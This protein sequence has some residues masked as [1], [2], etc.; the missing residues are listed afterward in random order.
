MEESEEG[1]D[2]KKGK[3]E[4]RYTLDEDIVVFISK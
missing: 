2:N 3:K 1:K 4:R